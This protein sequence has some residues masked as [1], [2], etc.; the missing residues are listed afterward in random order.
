MF[1]RIAARSI[2]AFLLVSPAFST[3]ESN[4]FADVNT[5]VTSAAMETTRDEGQV[6][7]PAQG[8]DQTSDQKQDSRTQAKVAALDVSKPS[9]KSSAAAGSAI[10][11]SIPAEPFGFDTVPVA[12][13]GIL[14]KWNGVRANIQAENDIL[15]RCEAN[16]E[17]CTAAARKFLKII[18]QGR[19]LT[20]RARIGI[21][22]R[23]INLAIRPGSDLATYGEPDVWATPLATFARGSGDCEDYAIAKFVALGKAGVAPGDLRIVVMHDLLGGEDHAVVAARLDGH[24]LTL[25]NRRMAMIE[26]ADIRSFR[27]TFV[28]DQNGV[29]RYVDAPLVTEAAWRR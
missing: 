2:A 28:I 4:A 18:S 16:A 7:V 27:P 26:D 17:L 12:S 3:G 5:P 6:Q 8:S 14:S 11:A 19:A 23:A 29:S 24:W 10:T 1:C 21:I 22:N 25:D 9:I 13:G 20:G 15:A